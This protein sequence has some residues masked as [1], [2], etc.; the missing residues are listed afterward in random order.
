[1]GHASVPLVGAKSERG[2][3]G[4]QEVALA[5]TATRRTL[6]IV[7]RETKF[8][9]CRDQKEWKRGRNG[10]AAVGKTGERGFSSTGG[11]G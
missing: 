3:F 10:N 4:K 9:K 5:R 6:R 2:A 7:R 11:K 8:V 1:M